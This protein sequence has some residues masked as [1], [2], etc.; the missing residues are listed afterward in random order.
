MPGN[1]TT[2]TKLMEAQVTGLPPDHFSFLPLIRMFSALVQAAVPYVLSCCQI[3]NVAS[4]PVGDV[5]ANL[6]ERSFLN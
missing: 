2:H 5:Q 1:E 4:S 6:P 3:G